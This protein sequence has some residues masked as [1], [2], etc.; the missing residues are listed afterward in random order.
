MTLASTGGSPVYRD[1]SVRVNG[2]PFDAEL[3]Q[4]RQQASATPLSTAA[5][6][7]TAAS[8]HTRNPNHASV[9]GDTSDRLL[10]PTELPEVWA[11]DDPWGE[12]LRLCVGPQPGAKSSV[13]FRFAAAELAT[14]PVRTQ[15]IPTTCLPGIALT[16]CLRV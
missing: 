6:A 2:R 15:A 12:G 8:K 1:V 16:D 7:A 3:R 10:V 5:A 11:S 13:T 4:R 9:S 14:V